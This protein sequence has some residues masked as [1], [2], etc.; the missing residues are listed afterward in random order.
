MSSSDALNYK[1]A[2]MKELK[3]RLEKDYAASPQRAKSKKET[4]TKSLNGS[5]WA[6]WYVSDE[7]GFSYCIY[8]H[9]LCSCNSVPSTAFADLN[10]YIYAYVT[11][12]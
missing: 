10:I 2:Q 1:F 6:V 11:K 7:W 9:I 5:G 4:K 8:L 12:P 3:N